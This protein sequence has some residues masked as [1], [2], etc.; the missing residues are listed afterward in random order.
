MPLW[1]LLSLAM[2]SA[3]AQ[4][5]AARLQLG[6]C[7]FEESGAGISSSCD[8]AV[9]NPPQKLGAALAALTANMSGPSV[10]MP[11]APAVSQTAPK[12]TLQ[13]TGGEQIYYVPPY[14]NMLEVELFGAAGGGSYGEGV[15]GT[16]GC[17]GYAYGLVSV[18]P[19]MAI[20]VQVG[21]GGG[22][23]GSS[24]LVPRAYP[25]GGV[26]PY[27]SSYTTGQGGG[28]S[29]ILVDG[30]YMLVAGGGG[31][32]G[33][34][35]GA[36]HHPNCGP[37]G[38]DA[39]GF[40]GGNGRWY[41]QTSSSRP[42]CDE[43]T[44]SGQNGAVANGDRGLHLQGGGFELSFHDTGAANCQGGG[45]D[46]W[47][48]GEKGLDAHMGGGGGTGYVGP[49]VVNGRS[50]PSASV[51][52]SGNI[53]GPSGRVLIT[54]YAA[55]PLPPPSPPLYE[56]WQANSNCHNG[57]IGG[58][59]LLGGGTSHA[60]DHARVMTCAQ[61]CKKL[62]G[63]LVFIVRHSD[64]ICYME[65]VTSLDECVHAAHEDYNMYKMV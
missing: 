10:P 47:Y 18:T 63:C 29:A 6:A 2:A 51:C 26:A 46:G 7:T 37:S 25:A 12:V 14:T 64:G 40:V 16:G 55:P 54:P 15:A 62:P 52:G 41:K 56:L 21:Q 32:A 4:D 58:E 9:G 5:D 22:R 49:G 65:A 11:G 8:I 45:G 44:T 35:G 27:R 50:T 60:A 59:T 3:L 17:G 31:G 43:K 34:K 36:S 42:D 61:A 33:G 39:G 30:N 28:R 19:G 13:S 23:R 1:G 24:T 57:E 38:G 20:T 53:D 48:G